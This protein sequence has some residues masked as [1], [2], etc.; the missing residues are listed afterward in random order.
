MGCWGMGIAECDEFL[1]VYDKFMEEYDDGR[2]CSEI[3]ADILSEYHTEFDDDDGVMH[4]VYFALAKAEWMCCQQSELVLNRVKNIVKSGANIEFYRELEASEENLKKRQK[5]LDK[6]LKSLIVPREKPR[7]RKRSTPAA[8]KVF[9]PMEIGECFAYKFGSGYRVFCVLERFNTQKGIERVT[10]AIL[11][12]EFDKSVL[13][14]LDF[15][16]EEI[17]IVFTVEPDDFLGASVI[18]SV[19]SIDVKKQK[20]EYL[21]GNS[22]FL[23]GNKQLFR[24]QI[25]HPM[26]ISIGEFLYQFK[27]NSPDA[28]ASFEVG[29]CYAY[30][31]RGEYRFAAVLD[32]PQFQ[33]KSCFL[34]AIFSA[35]SDT[36]KAD[37]ASLPIASL[38]V[39][40]ADGLPNLAG[41]QKVTCI[42]VPENLYI[43]LFGNTRYVGMGIL[44]FMRERRALEKK[45]L[46]VDN[47]Q[48]ILSH[49]RKNTPNA[50]FNLNA[51]DCY[52][53]IFG[54]DYRFVIIL[55]RFA[56]Y[57]EEEALVAV[58]SEKHHSPDD[59]Y[60]D[61][62][63]GHF[64]IYSIDTLPNMDSWVK[65]GE[66]PLSDTVKSYAARY[67]TTTSECVM[68]FLSDPS[69][70]SGYL[71]LRRFL[72]MKMPNK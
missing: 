1:E 53:F 47:I 18:K 40:E 54:G 46:A 2:P 15:V 63:I 8:E 42:D 12:R 37:F 36:P 32:K 28:L 43:R 61:D 51:G 34:V 25:L 52:S 22:A 10:V 29:G 24:G 26:R 27:E 49:C 11:N 44:D 6:F 9:P 35:F 7:K 38:N 57:G 31:L 64:G 68:K 30:K 20:K 59:D 17:G 70:S 33:G 58:L 41:W 21:L 5:N 23:L 69:Y 66:V 62:T 13:K 4:D 67:R 71:T 55:D 60:M 3:I 48:Q 16:Q 56:L 65:R 14:T 50:I 45:V 72:E 19:G 39:Y